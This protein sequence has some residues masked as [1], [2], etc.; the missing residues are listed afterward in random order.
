MYIYQY[1][2]VLEEIKSSTKAI[3]FVTAVAISR[4]VQSVS[5]RSFVFDSFIYMRV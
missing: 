5:D 4:G 2:L 3:P 1:I